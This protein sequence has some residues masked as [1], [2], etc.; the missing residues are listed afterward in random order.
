VTVGSPEKVKFITETHGI[1]ADRI[2]NS[3]DETFKDGVLEA[4]S[5]RGVDLVLNSLSGELLHA[6]WECVAEYGMMVEIGKTDL[7]GQGKLAM[8][9]FEQNRGYRGVDVTKLRANYPEATMRY[10]TALTFVRPRNRRRIS[11][12]KYA[13]HYLRPG[14]QIPEQNHRWI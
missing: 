14:S 8:E 3:R 10:V 1:A 7:I 2:F 6:S 13:V 12:L 5:G 9:I 4:T 11:I